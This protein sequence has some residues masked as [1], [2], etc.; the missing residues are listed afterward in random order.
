MVPRYISHISINKYC[1]STNTKEEINKQYS[2]KKYHQREKKAL[3]KNVQTTKWPM[4]CIIIFI[5]QYQN[6]SPLKDIYTWIIRFS[7]S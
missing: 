5:D 7:E 1:L 4:L 3:K 2:P 6:Q